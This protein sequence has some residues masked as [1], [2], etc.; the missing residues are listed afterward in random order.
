MALV[1]GVLLIGIACGGGHAGD[2]HPAN[3]PAHV[4]VVNHYA[5]PMDVYVTGSGINHRLGT[6]NP[7]MT[8]RF[9]VPPAL[10]GSGSVRLEAQGGPGQ[11]ETYESGPLLLSPGS[12]VDFVISA[13]LFNSTATLRP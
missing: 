1:P 4:E 3:T 6:V 9:A 13:Q 8:A 2:V 7:G 12:V 11:R 5:L 10:V